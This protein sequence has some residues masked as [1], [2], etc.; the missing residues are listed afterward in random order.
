MRA[1]IVSRLESES[2]GGGLP[3]LA[4][5]SLSSSSRSLDLALENTQLVPENQELKPEVGVAMTP[6]DEGLHEKMEDRVEEGDKRGR[7]S[8]Q[9]DPPPFAGPPAG[10]ASGVS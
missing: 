1:S 9:V 10:I 6:I 2:L 7:P 4:Y 8:R 3:D 5:E